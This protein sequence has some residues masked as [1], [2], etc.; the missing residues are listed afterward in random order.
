MSCVV[1]SN[2][3]ITGAENPE[4]SAAEQNWFC[5][6]QYTSSGSRIPRNVDVDSSI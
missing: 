3:D 5:R 2:N 1:L 4:S 6:D